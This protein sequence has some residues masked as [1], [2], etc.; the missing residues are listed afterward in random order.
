MAAWGAPIRDVDGAES[1][2]GAAGRRFPM[3]DAKDIF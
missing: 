2:A 1:D 3:I